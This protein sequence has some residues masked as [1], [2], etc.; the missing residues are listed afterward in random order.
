V[1]PPSQP[2]PV[3]SDAIHWQRPS[4]AIAADTEYDGYN[5]FEIDGTLPIAEQV[6]RARAQLRDIRFWIGKYYE[7]YGGI[8]EEVP[9]WGLVTAASAN[10]VRVRLLSD[11]PVTRA[12][13]FLARSGDTQYQCSVAARDGRA[14][15]GSVDHTATVT[16]RN[17]ADNGVLLYRP[18]HLRP[19]P[20][21]RPDHPREELLSLMREIG[22]MNL[23]LSRYREGRI[24]L[25]LPV[26][27]QRESRVLNVAVQ[28]HR[29]LIVIA[30]GADD[31][32]RVGDEWR[33]SRGSTF[34]GFMKI[35]RVLDETAV[36]EFD[37]QFP[38]NAAPPRR[39]DRAYTR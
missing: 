22:R 12:W 35:A 21:T 2:V 29:I 26:G 37:S 24:R 13:M 20:R 34:V 15:E 33:L 18:V 19:A 14:I 28:D 23:A 27:P 17:G 3:R 8:F 1:R 25:D 4:L 32:V 10:T 30:D 38:G 9:C 6:S 39:G 31:D 5:Q 36:G 7:R 11:L 16:D